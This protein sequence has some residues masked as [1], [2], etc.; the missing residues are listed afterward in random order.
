[1]LWKLRCIYLT[2]FC[3][4]SLNPFLFLVKYFNNTF[5][6]FRR[7][8]QVI[9]NFKKQNLVSNLIGWIDIC[10]YKKT[11]EKGKGA[12]ECGREEIGLNA[13]PQFQKLF[14]DL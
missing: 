9:S 12:K 14:N 6:V 4:G 8:N 13:S 5:F 3:V 2:K 1:M 11:G 7:M 10:T